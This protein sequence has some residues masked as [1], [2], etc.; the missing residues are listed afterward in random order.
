MNEDVYIS[1]SKLGDCPAI[2]MLV[3]WRSPFKGPQGLGG[4]LPQQELNFEQGSL[5]YPFW[6]GSNFIQKYSMW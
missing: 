2:A 5:D 4:L 3:F 6:R 1:N